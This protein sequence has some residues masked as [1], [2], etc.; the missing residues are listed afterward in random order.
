MLTL[1]FINKQHTCK[2]KTNRES[3]KKKAASQKFEVP[4]ALIDTEAPR[5]EFDVAVDVHKA[6]RKKLVDTGAATHAHSQDALRML[7]L[8]DP[9]QRTR[10]PEIL[11][12]PGTYPLS[13]R[14]FAISSS[15]LV[16][17]FAR[18]LLSAWPRFE[19]SS[20]LPHSGMTTRMGLFLSDPCWLGVGMGEGVRTE[21]AGLAGGVVLEAEWRAL[22]VLVSASNLLPRLRCT[23][24]TSSIF[25]FCTTADCAA[26]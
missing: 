13:R 3:R 14:I 6:A 17:C 11:A 26:T 19:C 24:P 9:F 10:R 4:S 20:S 18:S 1:N 25:P 15:T 12:V 16:P 8:H 5:I 23:F 7:G 22:V 21:P 2:R